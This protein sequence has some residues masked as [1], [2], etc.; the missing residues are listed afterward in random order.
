[1]DYQLITLP[2]GLRAVHKQV[3]GTQIA[4]CGFIIDVGTRHE[5]AHENGMAHFVE[6]LL[7][8]GTSKRKTFHILNRLDVIGGELNAYTT[9]EKTCL[10]AS[11]I[12]K[13]FDRAIELLSDLTFDSQFPEREVEKEKKVIVDEIQS[14]QDDYAESIF[15]EFEG[16][17]FAHNSL[18][19][20]ILGTVETVSGFTQA[21]LWDFYRRHYTA[22]NIV[23]SY[24][25]DMDFKTF[26]RKIHKQ[27][28]HL[29]IKP[30]AQK[31]SLETSIL[32]SS[33]AVFKDIITKNSTQAYCILGSLAYSASDSKRYALT[34]LNNI[35]C[36][37]SMN[38]RLNMS[39]REKNGLVYG[40]ESSYVNYSDTGYFNIFF[41]C[42]KQYYKRV[43]KLID[44]ELTRLKN[45]PLGKLQLHLAKQQFIGKILMSEESRV[46]L[47]LLL[48]KN[49]L[50]KG[51]VD[52][53]ETICQRIENLTSDELMLVA[54]E[55]F[56]ANKTSQLIY[57]PE[58]Q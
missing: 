53:L 29:N 43:L 36:S 16:K 49:I 9:K 25:G 6:H 46:D 17:I 27:F 41:S 38:S 23:F 11:F 40:I 33:K 54:N 8:K 28:T 22:S 21:S 44:K 30:S 12:S 14:Y 26:E 57:F 58:N 56:D 50:D 4:H 34:L 24:V 52:S 5:A 2:N 48:G 7:F 10:Y 32:D 42:D 1:M 19:T 39:I 51:F 31:T 37:D 20:N 47:M 45:K 13:Y 15:D 55:I 3:L 35:L 18:G